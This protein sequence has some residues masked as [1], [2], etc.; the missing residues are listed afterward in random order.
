MFEIIALL[1]FCASVHFLIL[2]FHNKQ[3][4][5]F[6]TFYKAL[7]RIFVFCFISISCLFLVKSV[8]D[9]VYDQS[10]ILF[11]LGFV[12]FR[13]FFLRDYQEEKK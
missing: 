5:T 12:V 6:K 1:L 4:F 9:N 11:V 10:I 8:T 3:N 13:Y 2:V 7:V